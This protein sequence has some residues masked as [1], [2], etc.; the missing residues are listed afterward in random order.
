M[1]SFYLFLKQTCQRENKL[2]SREPRN[3]E[4]SVLSLLITINSPTQTHFSVD[5]CYYLA[6]SLRRSFAIV[7]RQTCL[8]LTRFNF[9]ISSSTDVGGNQSSRDHFPRARFP[10]NFKRLL[11][12]SASVRFVFICWGFTRTWLER[13]TSEANGEWMTT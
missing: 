2:C 6:E 7:S 9:L 1:F 4:S 8:T 11:F 3:N 5:N 13:M 10:Q 12:W